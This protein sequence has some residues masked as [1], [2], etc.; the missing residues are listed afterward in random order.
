[1]MEPQI[2]LIYKYLNILTV[3][4]HIYQASY[5]WSI[6]KSNKP[7]NTFAFYFQRFPCVFID[8]FW[9][10][11]W[12]GPVTGVVFKL[13]SALRRWQQWEELEF[14]LTFPKYPTSGEA[15]A[16]KPV[17]SPVTGKLLQLF[18]SIAVRCHSKCITMS[19][20]PGTLLKML[21]N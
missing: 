4:H 18:C 8:L 9:N 7:F 2:I 15:K 19:L 5:C 6:N 20:Q 3:S 21:R 16:S 10:F 12:F 14:L 1:M 17:S 11:E 13:K